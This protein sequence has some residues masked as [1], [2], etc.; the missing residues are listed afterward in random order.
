METVTYSV[1]GVD[2]AGNVIFHWDYPSVIG[3]EVTEHAP[4]VA[5]YRLVGQSFGAVH[6]SA[7]PSRNIIRFIYEYVGTQ[8]DPPP[9]T[10]PPETPPPETPPPETPTPPDDGDDDTITEPGDDDTTTEPGDE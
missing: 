7:D 1:I 8:P 2:T 4:G 6:V 5:G 3:A 10:P 9:Q